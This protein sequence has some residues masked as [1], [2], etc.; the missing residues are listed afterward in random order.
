M[1]AATETRGWLTDPHPLS[2]PVLALVLP[3]SALLCH[4]LSCPT[5]PP[6]LSCV[7]PCPLFFVCYSERRRQ[8]GARELDVGKVGGGGGEG[9]DGA[10]VDSTGQGAYQEHKVRYHQ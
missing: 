5:C 7:F 1:H 6:L 3:C 2:C 9:A 10:A 4:V 8:G